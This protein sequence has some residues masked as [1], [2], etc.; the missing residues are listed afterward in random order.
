[1]AW[2]LMQGM[3]LDVLFVFWLVYMMTPRGHRSLM[4]L[5]GQFLQWTQAMP[6]KTAITNLLNLSD[7]LFLWSSSSSYVMHD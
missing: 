4:T 7:I 1:M 2:L 6:T 3:Y 5:V